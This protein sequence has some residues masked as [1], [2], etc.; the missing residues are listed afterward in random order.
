LSSNPFNEMAVNTRIFSAANAVRRKNHADKN[1]KRCG[2]KRQNVVS[3][4]VRGFPG[5]LLLS[6]DGKSSCLRDCEEQ[7][8]RAAF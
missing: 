6:G 7:T 3:V 5:G 2:Q 1:E 4:Q 8:M